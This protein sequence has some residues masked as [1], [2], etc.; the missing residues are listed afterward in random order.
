M[1]ITRDKVVSKCRLRLEPWQIARR[2]QCLQVYVIYPLT[3]DK[4]Q[5]SQIPERIRSEEKEDRQNP[6]HISITPDFYY[7]PNSLRLAPRN[8][9]ENKRLHAKNGF[10][11]S[12]YIIS[13]VEQPVAN[14]KQ[15]CICKAQ[16][17]FE[18]TIPQFYCPC[19]F[20]SPDLICLGNIYISQE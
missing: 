8:M 19:A 9:G 15:I 20:Q 12:M 2:K 3:H 10:K 14:R 18:I 4:I 5:Y 13:P 17:L 16:M 7:L 1:S 11:Q 6:S